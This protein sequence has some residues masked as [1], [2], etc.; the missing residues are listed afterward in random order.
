MVVPANSEMRDIN[1][2]L[3]R[4]RRRSCVQYGQILLPIALDEDVR[5]VGPGP[6][7][8]LPSGG[9]EVLNKREV[10]LEQWTVA[11]VEGGI[12]PVGLVGG[13]DAEHAGVDA[14]KE[15]ALEVEFYS[16]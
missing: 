15:A 8:W 3:Y 9:R 6:G 11:V 14:V 1:R 16:L 2:N 4:P 12:F 10:L 13:I 5:I 7:Y